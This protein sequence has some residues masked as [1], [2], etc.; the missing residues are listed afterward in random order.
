M[1]L[2]MSEANGQFHMAIAYAGKNSYLASSTNGCLIGSS[3]SCICTS[4]IER[5]AAVIF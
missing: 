5:S 2:K 4:N 1:H 3:A